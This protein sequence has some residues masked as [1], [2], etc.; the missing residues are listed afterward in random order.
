MTRARDAIAAIA[1]ALIVALAVVL[2]AGRQR[3]RVVDDCGTGSVEFS[4][5]QQLTSPQHVTHR[6]TCRRV[7]VQSSKEG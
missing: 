3:G 4:P 2:G 5:R 7:H 6:I 1:L